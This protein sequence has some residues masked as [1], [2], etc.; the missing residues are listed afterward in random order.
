VRDEQGTVWYQKATW[1]RRL[2]PFAMADVARRQR[3]IQAQS[4]TRFGGPV[5]GD[6]H[7]LPER[8][9]AAY[10]AVEREERPN[11]LARRCWGPGP[12]LVVDLPHVGRIWPAST[13]DTA[14]RATTSWTPSTRLGWSEVYRGGASPSTAILLGGLLLVKMWSL[15]GPVA[16]ASVPV[17]FG[18]LWLLLGAGPVRGV[19]SYAPDESQV[20]Q[21]RQALARRPVDG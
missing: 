16:A 7:E 17:L 2:V 6:D 18:S 20:R 11:A 13:P 14:S 21:L 19:Y 1:H 5:T 15:A 8:L 12:M 4:E 3:R 10:A 9:P